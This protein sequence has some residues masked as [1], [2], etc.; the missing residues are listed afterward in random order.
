M[1]ADQKQPPG[2]KANPRLREAARNNDVVKSNITVPKSTSPYAKAEF[3]R[4]MP[5]VIILVH[6]VND[7]GEAYS[8]QAEGLCAGLNDRLGRTD[9][10]PGNWDAPKECKTRAE[11]SYIRSQKDQGHNPIIPFYWGYR[12]VDKA[13]YDADQKR[14]EGELKARGPAGAEAPYDAYLIDGSKNS[15]TGHE[16]TDNFRNR[17]D[18]Q[19]CKNGGVFA[20]ATTNLIDMWG[21]GS[22]IIG[23]ARLVSNHAIPG[24][25]NSGDYTHSIY[26]N[27]HRIY[28]VEAAQRL[29]NL[30]IMIRRNKKSA[31]DSVNIVAHSQGTLIT[32]LANFIVKNSSSEYRPADCIIF[33]NSPYSLIETFVEGWQAGSKVQQSESARVTTMANFCQMINSAKVAGPTVEKMDKHGIASKETLKKLGHGRD[34]HGK[35]YNYFCPVDHTVSLRSIEGIGWQGV[36]N[37]WA[38]KFGSNFRQRMFHPGQIIDRPTV[39]EFPEVS[40]PAANSDGPAGEPRRLDGELF[41]TSLIFELPGNCNGQ[42][43]S[44]DFG[45][46]EAARGAKILIRVIDD[47]RNNPPK[48]APG[49]TIPMPLSRAALQEV[50]TQLDARGDGWELLSAET[51]VQGKLTITRYQTKKEMRAET[52]L[53]HVDDS[54]HSSIVNNEDASRYITA[55]DLAIGRCESHNFC[56]TDGGAFWQGLLRLADWR[57]SNDKD[58]AK[59]A[60]QGVLPPDLKSTMSKPPIISGIKNETVDMAEQKIKDAAAAA[61]K[62][63]IERMAKKNVPELEQLLKNQ[64]TGG[65]DPRQGNTD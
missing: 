47:P 18:G 33:N 17:L 28:M 44:P 27:P 63:D 10:K 65:Y 22:D 3:G 53:K 24:V 48:P 4:P 40:L 56:K 16:H 50:Q 45:V 32:M 55:Y 42:M 35:I 8:H 41:P 39:K 61:R 51:M 1:S 30:I 62:A 23:L 57:V 5:C 36:P 38:E 6:G 60:I 31:N 37:K 49:L 26:K 43:S 58:D 21:P 11:Y 19:F 64:K 13:T 20:N 54:F 59:Y 7:I 52:S 9:F 34:N 15:H 25:G 14:Y 29:A 2:Y 46:D 12:P